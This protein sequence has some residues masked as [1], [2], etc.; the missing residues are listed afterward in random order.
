MP[1]LKSV[2]PKKAGA[3][4]AKDAVRIKSGCYTRRIRHKKC[5]ERPD[6]FGRCKTCARL[7]IQC[8]KRP[9]WLRSSKVVELREKIEQ[10]PASQRMTKGPSSRSAEQE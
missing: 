7:H 1:N 5:D 3:P 8:A 4:K 6:E 10:F 9:D 2:S